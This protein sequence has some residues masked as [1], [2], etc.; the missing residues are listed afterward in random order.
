MANIESLHIYPIKGMRGISLES[1]LLQPEGF[2]YDRR[3]MLVDDNGTFISQRSHPRMTLFT[4]AIEDEML[5]VRYDDAQIAIRVD[6]LT[7]T[8]I[9]VSVFDDIMIATVVSEESNAWFSKHLNVSLRLVRVGHMTN[10]VKDFS[11]YVESDQSQTTVSF[12]DGYPYLI[13]SSASMDLLN[14]KMDNLLNIDR[15]RPNIVVNTAK[16]HDEDQWQNIQIGN[17]RMLVIKPCARCQVPTIDQQ[18]GI[19]GKQPNLALARYRR[20]G[21]KVNFGMNAVALTG[22]IL[23]VGDEI[24]SLT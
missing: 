19:S 2:E 24:Q 3:W 20:D 21:N 10:R 12:A 13:L 15:F 17:E 14:S 5:I 23:K 6:E 22:G 18:T 16:A 7:D 4:T 8:H 9:D 1:A 11:K